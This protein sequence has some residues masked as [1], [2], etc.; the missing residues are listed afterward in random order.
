MFG[1]SDFN[2][3]MRCCMRPIRLTRFT[4]RYVPRRRLDCL[5]LGKPVQHHEERSGQTVYHFRPGQ[6]FGVVWWRRHPDDRQHRAVA[7]VEALGRDQ[8]G[9]ELPGIQAAV[10][11]HAIVDQDGP[12]GQDGAVDALLDLIQE[13][14]QRGH[15]P[16][17]LPSNYWTEA[18][19]Q[20]LLRPALSDCLTDERIPCGI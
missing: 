13:L 8:P 11:V 16:E 9:H 4:A 7:I 18:V 20:I 17:K 12:A 6:V 2:K 3:K 1:S 5:C 14:K 10:A 15:E 19:H